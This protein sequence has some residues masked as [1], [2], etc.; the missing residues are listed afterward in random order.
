MK[1]QKIYVVPISIGE[2]T[3]LFASFPTLELAKMFG[4]DNTSTH[5]CDGSFTVIQIND[6]GEDEAMLLVDL[7][8]NI[9][10]EFDKKELNKMWR[11]YESIR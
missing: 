6:K 2:G 10:N 11:F 8:G 7:G 5:L 9:Q 3:G 4:T 1:K